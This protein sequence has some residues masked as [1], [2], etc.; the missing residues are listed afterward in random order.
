M[1]DISPLEKAHDLEQ[2]PENKAILKLALDLLG[3][4][5][6][7]AFTKL[8]KRGVHHDLMSPRGVLGFEKVIKQF[9]AEEEELGLVEVETEKNVLSFVLYLQL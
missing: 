7:S 4:G 8:Y 2:N 6:T 1:I 9:I 5:Y 3:S